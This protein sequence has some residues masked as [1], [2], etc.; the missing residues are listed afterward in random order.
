MAGKGSCP[1]VLSGGRAKQ[2]QGFWLRQVDGC[3]NTK[4][5]V[6]RATAFKKYLAQQ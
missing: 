5:K 4:R 2:K 1:G 3:N 6:Q